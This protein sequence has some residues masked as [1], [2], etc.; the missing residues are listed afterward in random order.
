MIDLSDGLRVDAGRLCRASGCGAVIHGDA[1][2][3]AAPLGALPATAARAL[4]I[5]GGE[6]YELLFTVPATKASRLAALRLGCPVTRIGEM[7]R[8]RGVTFVDAAGRRMALG[9]RAGHEHFS[10]PRTRRS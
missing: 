2:P 6:D 5:A 4:A 10:A 8:G 9:A 3:L 7:V 1:L